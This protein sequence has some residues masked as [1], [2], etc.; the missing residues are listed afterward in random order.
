MTAY[1]FQKRGSI[2]LPLFN[3]IFK[4]GYELVGVFGGPKMALTRFLC[5][6]TGFSV[7]SSKIYVFSCRSVLKRDPFLTSPQQN[8]SR[9][10][11]FSVSILMDLLSPVHSSYP[12]RSRS[13]TYL[14]FRI[15]RLSLVSFMQ[16][17]ARKRSMLFNNTCYTFSQL[18]SVERMA[19]GELLC[20]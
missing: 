4:S 2:S 14:N 15:M 12:R 11:G 3:P 16:N 19:S 17:K 8:V 9:E 6:V 13:W 5:R 20:D 18:P 10:S 1:P 7:K